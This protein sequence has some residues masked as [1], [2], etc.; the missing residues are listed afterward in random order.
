[1]VEEVDQDAICKLCNDHYEWGS[2]LCEGS[3]CEEAHE[4][5]LEEQEEVGDVSEF[6]VGVG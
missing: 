5:Y 4:M 2:S 3:R 6:K 1:M